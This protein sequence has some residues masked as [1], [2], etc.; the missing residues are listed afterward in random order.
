M[1]RKFT[2][3]FILT[4]LT[5]AMLAVSADAS[6]STDLS[7]DKV[8]AYGFSFQDSESQYQSSGRGNTAISLGTHTADG[9][10]P[11]YIVGRSFED[12]PNWYH[13]GRTVDWRNDPI[14][15]FIYAFQGVGGT[16]YVVSPQSAMYDYFNPLVGAQGERLC[17]VDHLQRAVQPLS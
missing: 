12:R 15:H 9:N 4:L 1:T 17:S 16:D 7:F 10:S 13:P 8:K 2:S 6:R 3:L 11:G 5:V 14:I